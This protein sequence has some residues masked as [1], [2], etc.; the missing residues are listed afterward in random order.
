MSS[1]QS[2]QDKIKVLFIQ[3]VTI[4]TQLIITVASTR[5]SHLRRLPL[6]LADTVWRVCLSRFFSPFL[7]ADNLWN[8]PPPQKVFPFSAP[9]LVVFIQAKPTPAFRTHNFLTTTQLIRTHKSS[10]CF[11]CS[12]VVIVYCEQSSRDPAERKESLFTIKR[13]GQILSLEHSNIFTGAQVVR[14]AVFGARKLSRLAISKITLDHSPILPILP[15]FFSGA[16]GAYALCQFDFV[17][18]PVSW[19]YRLSWILLQK[20]VFSACPSCRYLHPW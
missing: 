18:S 12:F 19:R 11:F 15:V 5:C 17:C 13:S 8:S 16:V 10:V 20:N 7:T 4:S 1:E 14:T 3:I 2:V 9:C 6:D